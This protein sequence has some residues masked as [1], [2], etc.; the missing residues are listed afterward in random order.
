[1]PEM[2]A[3]EAHA[4]AWRY[5]RLG[6]LLQRAIATPELRQP[7]QT[8]PYTSGLGPEQGEDDEDDYDDEEDDDE[9]ES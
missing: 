3:Q 6:F 1:L 9:E 2:F 5:G 4:I 8:G 7:I